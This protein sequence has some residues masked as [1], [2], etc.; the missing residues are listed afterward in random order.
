MQS[1]E[2]RKQRCADALEVLNRGGCA[3]FFTLT[4]VDVVDLPTIRERWRKFRHEFLRLL[5]KRGIEH[6][7][8]VMNYELHPGYLN[9]IVKDRRV[10]ERVIRSDGRPHGWHIHGVISCRVPLAD[11]RRLAQAALFGRVNVKRVTSKGISDYLVKH[12]L[13]AYRG[14]TKRERDTYRGMRL[15]LVNASR[16]LPALDDYAYR[17]ELRTR[18]DEIMRLERS[19]YDEMRWQYWIDDGDGQT[20]PTDA[21]GNVLPLKT[22]DFRVMRTRSEACALLGLSSF[23]D[24]AYALQFLRSGGVGAFLG[25]V[26]R[27]QWRGVFEQHELRSGAV[28]VDSRERSDWCVNDDSQSGSSGRKNPGSR[29]RDALMCN[30]KSKFRFPSAVPG[31]VE[32]VENHVRTSEP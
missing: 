28:T 21:R 22:P 15:R 16:G 17:S 2:I 1:R 30:R 20:V 14:L 7:E 25:A 3:V 18:T 19:S 23:A 13:K 24:L 26:S 5:R 31:R 10:V 6:V 29:R 27:L 9:K 4:T 32:K 12:A 8:Y 11:F